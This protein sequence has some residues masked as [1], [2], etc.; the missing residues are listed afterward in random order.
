M[1]FEFEKKLKLELEREFHFQLEQELRSRFPERVALE[2][3]DREIFKKDGYIKQELLENFLKKLHFWVLGSDKKLMQKL[4][5]GIQER[6]KFWIRE[7]ITF[8]NCART[9]SGIR[10][11]ITFITQKEEIK[12]RIQE[13]NIS[14]EIYF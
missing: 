2:I 7:E 6:I 8:W 13:V 12:F 1:R 9:T 4:H 3:L 10:V 14:S 11:R 5:S